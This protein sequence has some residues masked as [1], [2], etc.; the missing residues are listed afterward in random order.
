VGGHRSMRRVRDHAKRASR[1]MCNEAAG[2]D[3]GTGSQKRSNGANEGNG[4]DNL[5]RLRVLCFS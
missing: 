2:V 4:K 1:R 5:R 3:G